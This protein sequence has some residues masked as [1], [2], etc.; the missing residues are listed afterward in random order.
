MTLSVKT[1]KAG[2]SARTAKPSCGCT[3]TRMCS[4]HHEEWRILH[5]SALAYHR[6]ESGGPTRAEVRD[7]DDA[8]DSMFK[9]TEEDWLTT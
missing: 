4:Q 1:D 8:R 9:T 7:M 3:S 2:I 5:E 6:A